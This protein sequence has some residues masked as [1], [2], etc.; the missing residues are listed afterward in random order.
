[1]KSATTP[2]SR[3]DRRDSNPPNPRGSW[4]AFGGG[5]RNRPPPPPPPGK[6]NPWPG[7]P[8]WAGPRLRSSVFSPLLEF[9]SLRGG[10]P[11]WGGPR[12]GVL[13]FHH[14]ETDL[15][16]CVCLESGSLPQAMATR[17]KARQPVSELGDFRL[18]TA[19]LPDFPLES[20]WSPCSYG[21][22][23]IHVLWKPPRDQPRYSLNF[24]SRGG[25]SGSL[26]IPFRAAVPVAVF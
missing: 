25:F 17:L 22:R 9:P 21:V 7:G 11:R 15:K 19:D 20:C 4:F 16:T 10:G 13:V 23:A 6:N 18:S 26:V 24:R 8:G 1:M 2:I 12:G 5:P 14:A 3:S